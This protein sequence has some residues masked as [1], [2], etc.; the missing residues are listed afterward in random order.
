MDGSLVKTS[1]DRKVRTCSSWAQISAGKLGETWAKRLKITGL[2]NADN[3]KVASVVFFLLWQDR[4]I[5]WAN[6]SGEANTVPVNHGS[7]LISL[8][9]WWFPA[10]TEIKLSSHCDSR[11][12]RERMGWEPTI[13]W[14]FPFQPSFLRRQMSL[15]S[16][17]TH[18]CLNREAGS[19]SSRYPGSDQLPSQMAPFSNSLPH[20]AYSC[21]AVHASLGVVSHKLIQWHLQRSKHA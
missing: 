11:L 10:E 14:R 20:H 3:A 4:V 16:K 2:N 6:E 18:F 19:R 13:L 12:G 21:S 15:N 5:S 1:L 17:A 8:P 9:F 7:T